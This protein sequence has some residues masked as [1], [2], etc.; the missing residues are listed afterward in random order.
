VGLKNYLEG[1]NWQVETAEQSLAVDLNLHSIAALQRVFPAHVDYIGLEVPY[2]ALIRP[3]P[4]ALWP[5]KPEG[6]SVSIE[7]AVGAG[8]GWTVA[9]TF[10]GEAYMSGGYLA[11]LGIS[12][13]FGF[14]TAWWNRLASPNNSQFG[15]LIY[16]SGF[17]AA[18][19]SM[20]S[21]FSFTTAL[22]PTLSAII[23]GR[24][25]ITKTADKIEEFRKARAPQP[26]PRFPA[27]V[28]LKPGD[29]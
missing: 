14:L 11:V 3:I 19:I 23:G 17:F 18:V 4:R 27:Q 9:A 25:L 21:L 8:E 28:R 13:F 15:V 12:L 5:G 16:A 29:R 22:L 1:R 2:I 10:A 26:R 24:F 7:Q 20:R 6:L